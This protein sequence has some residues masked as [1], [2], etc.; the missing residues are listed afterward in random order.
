MNKSVTSICMAGFF[1]WTSPASAGVL[2]FRC[3]WSIR[4]D[5]ENTHIVVL[6]LDVDTS[7]LT[8]HQVPDRSAYFNPDHT[9]RDTDF[10]ESRRVWSV[11]YTNGKVKRDGGGVTAIGETSEEWQ[12]VKILPGQISYGFTFDR[13]EIDGNHVRHDLPQNE[14]ITSYLINTPRGDAYMSQRGDP[15]YSGYTPISNG[16]CTSR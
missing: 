5:P 1:V 11:D 13:Y 14:L 4:G 10:S 8:V 7:K 3:D 2:H 6:F 9:F 12:Y 16:Q 15:Q